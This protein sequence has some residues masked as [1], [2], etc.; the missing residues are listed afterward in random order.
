MMDLVFLT[1]G[2]CS[3]TKTMRANLD[4]ALKSMGLP[5]DYPVVDLDTL[6]QADARRGYPTPTLLRGGRD[7][8]GMDQPTPPYTNRCRSSQRIRTRRCRR[9]TCT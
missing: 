5:A 3:N 7:L 4:A 1:R 9:R 8:F 6:S 2:G